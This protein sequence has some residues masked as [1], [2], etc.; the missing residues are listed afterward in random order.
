MTENSGVAF[1][2]TIALKR[3]Q[4]LSGTISMKN[5]IIYAGMGG[6]NSWLYR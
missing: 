6:M 2:G 5:V 1:R 3:W 4:E